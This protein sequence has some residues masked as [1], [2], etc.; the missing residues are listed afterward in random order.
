M[1]A[2]RRRL[3]LPNDCANEAKIIHRSFLKNRKIKGVSRGFGIRF[4]CC[5]QPDA[6][7]QMR[8]IGQLASGRG[9]AV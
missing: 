5:Q 1:T 7:N 4:S 6:M 9:G 8:T 3:R 2:Q